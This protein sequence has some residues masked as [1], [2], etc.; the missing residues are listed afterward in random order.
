[1]EQFASTQSGSSFWLEVAEQA[2]RQGN[3]Q[4]C[5][6]AVSA[7]I[8]R[9]REQAR[10]AV[11]P[12]ARVE[13]V[14]TLTHWERELLLDEVITIYAPEQLNIFA[15]TGWLWNSLVEQNRNLSRELDQLLE[16][17]SW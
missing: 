7:V 13:V 8:T 1:M 17:A 5:G 6:L 3:F 16:G 10:Q 4:L 2:V 15:T 12:A 14:R 9:G 11:R